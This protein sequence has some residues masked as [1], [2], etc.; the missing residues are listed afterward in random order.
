[1]TRGSLGENGVI[2]HAEK[3]FT[4]NTLRKRKKTRQTTGEE[5]RRSA[6]Q[7]TQS[8]G[9]RA[10]YTS[11]PT[12][13]KAE[14]V[15]D[16]TDRYYRSQRAAE[17]AARRTESAVRSGGAGSSTHY[18]SSG[19]E[20]GGS[21]GSFPEPSLY[22]RRQQQ[23]ADARREILRRSFDLLGTAAVQSQSAASGYYASPSQ[24]LA[25]ARRQADNVQAIKEANARFNE[26]KRVIDWDG[27]SALVSALEELDRNAGWEISE[28]QANT[29]ERRRQLLLEKLR[30]GD[31]SAGNGMRSG[32]DAD[33]GRDI[34]ES[35]AKGIGGAGVD[36]FSNIGKHLERMDTYS[37]KAT[38]TFS[39][40]W[41][42]QP[43]GTSRRER[44]QAYEDPASQ[45][46]WKRIDAAADR[47]SGDSA[48]V[49]QRA[50]E[51]KSFLGEIGVDAAKSALEMGFDSGVALATGGSALIPMGARVYGQSVGKARRAGA[52]LDRQTA[53][54]MTRTAIELASEKLFDGVAGIYGAGAADD[55]TEALVRRLADSGTGRTLLRAVI[56][57][58]GEGTEELVSDLLDPL[59]EAMY[60]DESV[61]ELYRQLDPADM[62][63]DYLI[64]S[65]IGLFG[66]G[67]DIAAG[68]NAEANRTLKEL[69]ANEAA[70]LRRM[71]EIGHL[72]PEGKENAA[73]DGAAEDAQVMYL[74]PK[75]I[76]TED[77]LPNY[78]RTGSRNNKSKQKALTEGKRIILT[79]PIEIVNYIRQSI[80]SGQSNAVAAYGRVGKRL[81]EDIKRESK[82]TIDIAG[83]YLELNPYDLQHSYDEHHI[84]K[85]EGDI[86]LTEED[87]ESIP[88]YLE[89]YDEVLYARTYSSNEKSFC[90]SKR[91]SRGRIIII[92][93][94]SKSR[95]SVHFKNA[96]GVSEEKYNNRILPKYRKSPANTGGSESSNSTPPNARTQSNNIIAD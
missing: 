54:A 23:K 79:S 5:S 93:I 39:D 38:D 77:D 75:N 43:R 92:E 47:L 2:R 69:D 21:S 63:Y 17:T 13:E 65:T 95:N 94:V 48:A 12:K 82:N 53:Y 49:L 4:K 18:S 35:T 70:Y 14:Y 8:G 50:K 9:A 24:Q 15:R 7:S 59:A 31:L 32:T 66:S 61:G 64:G 45:E 58:V 84:A 1:M 16:L 52:N 72:R 20:F 62:L 51:G 74:S 25:L 10:T 57:S 80:H 88:Y 36:L 29:A 87:Y 81:A 41:N 91:I 83:K 28:E 19:R 60:R 90:V 40:L 11:L 56:G 3:D 46:K 96:I 67:A 27:R 30:E 33:T 44:I 34:V 26:A 55:I 85:M 68:Q 42:G 37:W 6:Q 73:L 76:L 78:L 86:V 71:E 22:E 89:T